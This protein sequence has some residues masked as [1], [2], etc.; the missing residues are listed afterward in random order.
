VIFIIYT[1]HEIVG[2]ENQEALAVFGREVERLEI[3]LNLMGR[4]N[5]EDLK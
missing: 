5:L 4:E 2:R 1:I 3:Y